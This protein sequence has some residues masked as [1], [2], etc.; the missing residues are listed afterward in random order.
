MFYVYLR[1]VYKDWM[2]NQ[3]ALQDTYMYPPGSY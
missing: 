2:G 1:K 3:P